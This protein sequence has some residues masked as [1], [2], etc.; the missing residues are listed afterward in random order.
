LACSLH[1]LERIIVGARFWTE[2]EVERLL[3]LVEDGFLWSSAQG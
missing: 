1:R 3:G 2:E